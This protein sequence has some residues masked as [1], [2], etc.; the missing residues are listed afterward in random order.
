MSRASELKRRYGITREE[1]DELL[2]WQQGRCFICLKKPRARDPELA[3]DHDH[4]TGEI[5]GLLCAPCNHGQ[6]GLVSEDPS[7]Y[8]RA[9][10]YL[11]D[12]PA[13]Y[14]IGYRRVPDAPP[15][16]EEGP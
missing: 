16:P 10:E 8:R 4:R 11:E 14:A 1:Y 6:L 13:K 9:A 3:V 2:Y 7:Y 15:L 12:S 5:R